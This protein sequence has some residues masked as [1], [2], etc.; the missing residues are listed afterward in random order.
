[1]R[2]RSLRWAVL[3][4]GLAAG[5][6]AAQPNL[7]V[8]LGLMG[9][10]TSGHLRYQTSREGAPSPLAES[11]TGAA[12]GLTLQFKAQRLGVGLG[13]YEAVLGGTLV[14]EQEQILDANTRLS[15]RGVERFRM[16][17]FE[18]PISASYYVV[19]RPRLRWQ[20]GGGPWLG[21]AE[22]G[23]YEL[24]ERVVT[25]SAFDQV[26][27]TNGIRIEMKKD[28]MTRNASLTGTTVGVHAFTALEYQL[29]PRWWVAARARYTWGLTDVQQDLGSQ[30]WTEDLYTHTLLVGIGLSYSLRT[31]GD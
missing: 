18:L 30:P 7:E 17:Y 13:L 2:I 23:A 1:M 20:L 4:L 27:S 9:G 19:D 12:W 14:R 29:G 16:R 28:G 25:T 8:S 3:L 31:E 10:F 26:I 5:Q 24:Q 6:A 22:S 21:F 11:E 15:Y